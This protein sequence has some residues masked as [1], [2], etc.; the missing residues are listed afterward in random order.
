[1]NSPS[2]SSGLT[3]ETMPT[4]Q[5]EAGRPLSLAW[6]GDGLVARTRE[7]W[8]R[9]LGH[10]VTEEKAIEIILNYEAFL[11][12]IRGELERRRS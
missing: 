12:A 7:V 1:M 8:S 11:K 5:V 10:P 4:S 6:I 3:P 9:H 2:E